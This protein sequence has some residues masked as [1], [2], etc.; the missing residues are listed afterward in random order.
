L[1]ALLGLLTAWA[2]CFGCPCGS[3]PAGMYMDAG[4]LDLE[5]LWDATTV[6]LAIVVHHPDPEV[7][8]EDELELLPGGDGSWL[9]P[10]GIEAISVGAC[11]FDGEATFT[12]IRD[13]A[14]LTEGVGAPITVPIHPEYG[15]HETLELWDGWLVDV[16][17]GGW[18]A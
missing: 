13:G 8:M 16:D 11:G 10:A 2:G 14:E 3:G 5:P 18:V 9:A 6:R 17:W 4:P 12:L 7:V 15:F 1:L